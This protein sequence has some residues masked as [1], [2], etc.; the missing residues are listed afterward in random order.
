MGK[1]QRA[2]KMENWRKKRQSLVESGTSKGEM[3]LVVEWS[4]I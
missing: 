2:V 4:S 1:G 3:R